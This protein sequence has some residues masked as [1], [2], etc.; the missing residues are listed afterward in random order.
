MISCLLNN[1]KFFH[2]LKTD[3]QFGK[4]SKLG[5]LYS[6]DQKKGEAKKVCNVKTEGHKYEHGNGH[7]AL[8]FKTDMRPILRPGVGYV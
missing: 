3:I 6:M 2:A 4:A 7:N 8:N 5:F 1:L